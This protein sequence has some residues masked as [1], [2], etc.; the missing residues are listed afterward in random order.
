[1]SLKLVRDLYVNLRSRLFNNKVRNVYTYGT[2]V[3][4]P[5]PSTI[6]DTTYIKIVVNEAFISVTFTFKCMQLLKLL[7]QHY[8]FDNNISY[9]N[10]SLLPLPRT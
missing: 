3:S 9:R 10:L 5:G 1:M 8:N 2:A 6:Y 4:N 7:H